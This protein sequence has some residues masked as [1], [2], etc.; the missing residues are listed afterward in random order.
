M[1]FSTLDELNDLELSVRLKKSSIPRSFKDKHFRIYLKSDRY[2]LM[3]KTIKEYRE[4]YEKEFSSLKIR[5][6]G[7]VY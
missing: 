3:K 1:I 7:N 5:L 6:G 2:A 4:K